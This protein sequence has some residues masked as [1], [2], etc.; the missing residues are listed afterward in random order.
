[1][2][3][4]YLRKVW[5]EDPKNSGMLY[6]EGLFKY[7]MHINYFGDLMLFT[8]FSMI[9]HNIFSFVIPLLMFFLFTFVNIPMLD[10]Y[11]LDRYGKE[12]EEYRGRTK[13]FVPYLY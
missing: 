9:T 1:T 7:S 10:K 4:E 11:L 6:T 12:F 8:G 13:K 5:K 2:G 3:S